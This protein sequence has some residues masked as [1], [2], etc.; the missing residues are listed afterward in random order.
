MHVDSSE[1]GSEPA[2]ARGRQHR[3]RRGGRRGWKRHGVRGVNFAFDV[4]PAE[5]ITA[6][7]TDRGVLEPPYADSIRAAASTIAS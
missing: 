1:H 4:T 3:D 5:L 2:A 7:I 6:I